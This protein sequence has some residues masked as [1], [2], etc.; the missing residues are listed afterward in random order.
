[1]FPSDLSFHLAGKQTTASVR[2][3]VCRNVCV[4]FSVT[5]SLSIDGALIEAHDVL[6]ERSSLVTKDVFNLNEQG[7]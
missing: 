1:M 3:D 5:V 7:V 4:L 6:S 2:H